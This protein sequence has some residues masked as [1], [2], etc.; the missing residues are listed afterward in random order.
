MKIRELGLP[1]EE[2]REKFEQILQGVK[3]L[4]IEKKGLVTDEE[5]SAIAR[6]M[7]V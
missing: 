4:S 5:F 7:M 3:G 1:F 6:K 2:D